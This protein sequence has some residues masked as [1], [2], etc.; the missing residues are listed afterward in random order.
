LVEITLFGRPGV[1]TA[2]SC[3]ARPNFICELEKWVDG[4]RPA[5]LVANHHRR[6]LCE[7][8]RPAVAG[9]KQSPR[10]RPGGGATAGRARV[11]RSLAK[12]AV[13][14]GKGVH[15]EAVQ[16]AC[17]GVPSEK[18][19]RKWRSGV[20]WR[21]TP[22]RNYGGE[23]PCCAP[24]LYRRAGPLDYGPCIFLLRALLVLR[25]CVNYYRSGLE[26]NR[27]LGAISKNQLDF[28]A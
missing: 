24:A 16:S 4:K 2:G 28:R 21:W 1:A 10:A 15:R 6:E 17:I 11:C 7:S 14:R 22:R 5:A 3:R 26:L 8:S 12:P 27:H 20:G 25:R 13:G 19:G 9:C 18:E 23:A